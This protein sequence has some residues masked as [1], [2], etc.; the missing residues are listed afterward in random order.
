MQLAVL[1][2]DSALGCQGSDPLHNHLIS[3]V[4]FPVVNLTS[5]ASEQ[6]SFN[7]IGYRKRQSISTTCPPNR[8]FR[9]SLQDM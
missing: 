6:V 2:A 9:G 1:F 8:D 4:V 7:A 5:V 3:S